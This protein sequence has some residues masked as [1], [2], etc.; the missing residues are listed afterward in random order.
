MQIIR[1]NLQKIFIND[2]MDFL[3]YHKTIKGNYG[4]SFILC[5]N[6]YE[7][8]KYDCLGNNGHYHIYDKKNYRE[9]YF[10]NNNPYT[11]IDFSIDNLS[12]NIDNYINSATDPNIKNVSYDKKDIIDKLDIVKNILVDY[13]NKYYSH[14]R[15]K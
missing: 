4:T 9:I 7:Y 1:K 6:N 14:L 3:V 5:V 8:I 11:Q 15:N 10:D 12:K 13:E 2:K